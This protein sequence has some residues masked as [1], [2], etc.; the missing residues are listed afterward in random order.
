MNRQEQL[1]HLARRLKT[2]A[3]AN[4]WRAL[5]QADKELAASLPRLAA[6]APWSEAERASLLNL[7]AIH[8]EAYQHCA[9]ESARLNKHLSD[10]QANREGWIA[11]ALNGANDLNESKT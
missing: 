2:A 5:G 1:S 6:A 8:G 9:E 3:D 7:R 10:M 4:D 11:Y